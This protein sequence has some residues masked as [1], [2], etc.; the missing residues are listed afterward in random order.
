MVFMGAGM[1]IEAGKGG[2][3]GRCGGA[4]WDRGGVGGR[5]LQAR[6]R[7]KSGDV[8][9]EVPRISARER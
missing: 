8:V 3:V 1:E 4:A 6:K 5:F 9:S 2:I 7:E